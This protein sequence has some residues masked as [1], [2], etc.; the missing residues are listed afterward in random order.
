MYDTLRMAIQSMLLETDYKTDVGKDK[1]MKDRKKTPRQVAGEKLLAVYAELP[2]SKRDVLQKTL[3]KHA[4]ISQGHTYIEWDDGN[5]SARAV[6][7]WELKDVSQVTADAWFDWAA[8]IEREGLSAG[9]ARAAILD[10][11]QEFVWVRYSE[12]LQSQAHP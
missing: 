7:Y 12:D 1:H 6:S 5:E 8:A 3:L 2:P 10:L 9:N 11:V 4:F